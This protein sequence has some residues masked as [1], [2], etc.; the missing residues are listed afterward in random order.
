MHQLK[1]KAGFILIELIIATAILAAVIPLSKFFI[2][3]VRA[4]NEAKIQ[5]AANNLA[6]RY[7]EEY[8]AKSIDAISS[9]DNQ[10]E[11]IDGKEYLVN[12]DLDWISVEESNNVIATVLIAKESETEVNVTLSNNEGAVVGPFTVLANNTY[13]LRF[14]NNDRLIWVA[15]DDNFITITDVTGEEKHLNLIV[16]GNPQITVDL[17]N[18]LDSIYKLVINKTE[19]P[20]APDFSLTIEEEA[21]ADED[22]NIDAL[23]R[24]TAQ[25]EHNEKGVNI[26]VTVADKD[27]NVLARIAETRKIEW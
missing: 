5:Q 12:V 17:Q 22:M 25:L 24:E 18:R 10:E 4:S 16:K 27:S 2:D 1:G 20:A 14:D 7:L 15:D 3:A 26:I 23:I 19:D 21:G 13:A 6:Q 11:E 8:K 9:L